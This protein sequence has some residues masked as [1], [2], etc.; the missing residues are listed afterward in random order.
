M[1]APQRSSYSFPSPHEK[2]GWTFVVLSK[3]AYSAG[4]VVSRL[5][6]ASF[7]GNSQ[8]IQYGPI[9]R[10]PSCC[11]T[12]CWCHD[13]DTHYSPVTKSQWPNAGFRELVNVKSSTSCNGLL[14]CNGS[15]ALGCAHVFIHRRPLAVS[16]GSL[17]SRTVHRQQ[18]RHMV[19]QW[20]QLW[21]RESRRCNPVVH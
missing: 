16:T 20:G 15:R 21:D 1:K 6:A 11:A 13:S 5:S 2:Y 9:F 8:S 3:I 4:F 19:P 17:A 14:V 18:Q 10:Q 12:Q 7:V